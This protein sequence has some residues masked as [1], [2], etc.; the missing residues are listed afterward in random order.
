MVL[1]KKLQLIKADEIKFLQM[2]EPLN[3]DLKFSV[4]YN[5]LENATLKLS[6]NIFVNETASCKMKGS[7]EIKNLNE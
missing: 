2:I 7:F 5:F 6:G 4:H 1:N 3:S